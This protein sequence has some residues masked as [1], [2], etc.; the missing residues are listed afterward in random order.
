MIRS[1]ARSLDA[2]VRQ[3]LLG[4]MLARAAWPSGEAD[5]QRLVIEAARRLDAMTVAELQ[6]LEA[7]APRSWPE[8]FSD[9][10]PYAR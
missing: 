3:R 2:A 10:D 4:T 9:Y 8:A 7:L 5:A 1:P 6:T